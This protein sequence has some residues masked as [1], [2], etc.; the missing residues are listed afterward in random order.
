MH[1]S[2]VLAAA[3]ATLTVMM[4][5]HH[6]YSSVVAYKVL[7]SRY[8]QA[9]DEILYYVYGL[10]TTASIAQHAQLVTSLCQLIQSGSF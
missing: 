7:G 8:T 4:C 3:T 1:S 6:V 2:Q 10:P 5:R 9:I